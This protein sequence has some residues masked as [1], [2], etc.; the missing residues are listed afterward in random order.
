MS[1]LSL[2]ETLQISAGHGDCGD[3]DHN[4]DHDEDDS[5]IW[6]SFTQQISQYV[7]GW[8]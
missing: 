1:E 4:H 2:I 8:F 3:H 5:D 6:G 7:K